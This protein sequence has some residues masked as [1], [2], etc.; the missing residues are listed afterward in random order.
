MEQGNVGG[1]GG[2]TVIVIHFEIRASFSPCR[3]P[4]PSSRDTCFSMSTICSEL[5]CYREYI[6]VF[7]NKLHKVCLPKNDMKSR[8]ENRRCRHACKNAI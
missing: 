3:K 7:C 4:L 2:N 8:A 5:N 1:G 6:K